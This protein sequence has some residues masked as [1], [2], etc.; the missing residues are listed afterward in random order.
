MGSNLRVLNASA[1]SGKTTRLVNEYLYLILQNS[2]PFAFKEILAITF[3]NKAAL[4]MKQRIVEELQTIAFK[5]F[6]S[7]DYLTELQQKTDLTNQEFKERASNSLF[8]ILH[9]YSDFAISTIDAFVLKILKTFSKDLGLPSGFEVNLDE[10]KALEQAILNLIENARDEKELLKFITE[11][12]LQRLSEEKSWNVEYTL[13]DFCKIL[14]TAENNNSIKQLAK[15]PLKDFVAIREYIQPKIEEFEKVLKSYGDK[16]YQLIEE[17][18]VDLDAFPQGARSG[19]GTYFKKLADGE[20]KEL[21]KSVLSFLNKDYK[22]KVT[23]EQKDGIDKVKEELRV[24]LKELEEFEKEYRTAYELHKLIL[25]SLY[26]MG[27]LKEVASLLEKSKNEENYILISDFNKI[28]TDAIKEEPAPFIY[29]RTG[30]R[31]K[32]IFIDEFQDTSVIQWQNLFPLVENSLGG[33]NQVLI[34]GDVKQSIY[35]WRGGEAEQLAKFPEPVKVSASEK[36]RFNVLQNFMAKTEPLV[37][38]YRSEKKIIEFNNFLFSIMQENV[39][40]NQKSFFSDFKQDTPKKEDQGYVEIIFFEDNDLLKETQLNAVLSIVSKLKSQNL[41]LNNIA[42][43]CRK[44]DDVAEMVSYLTQKS[45]PVISAEGLLVKNSKRVCLIASCIIYLQ[46]FGKSKELN[47]KLSYWLIKNGFAELSDLNNLSDNLLSEVFP[48]KDLKELNDAST[49]TVA[50][51]LAN[52]FGFLTE[53]DAFVVTFLNALYD[54]ELEIHTKYATFQDWWSIEKDNIAIESPENVNAVQVMSIHK[55]K[56]LQFET[57]ILPYTWYDTTLRNYAEWVKLAPFKSNLEEFYLP[58]SK[59]GASIV[60]FSENHETEKNKT[61]LDSFNMLYVACTRPKKNLYIF[62]KLK[63]KSNGKIESLLLEAASNFNNLVEV[64]TNHWQ[65]GQPEHSSAK[66][67]TKQNS[68]EVFRHFNNWKKKI[69]VVSKLLPYSNSAMEKGIAIHE[70][71]EQVTSTESLNSTWFKQLEGGLQEK[72][73]Q[74]VFHPELTEAYSEKNQLNER[75]ILLKDGTKYRPDKVTITNSTTFLIDYKTG[76]K[77]ETHKKQLLEYTDA[78]KAMGYN[79][80]K[81]FLAYVD[82]NEVEPIN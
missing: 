37:T 72:I 16:G 6:S 21:N 3:T 73:K 22:S 20:P 39:A 9:N 77:K 81:P 80:I 49:A 59:D 64:E 68:F 32:H 52:W 25:K 27:M 18:Q 79:N 71:F 69:K 2:N 15:H 23:Q 60:G 75:E 35:R 41:P 51:T 70:L 14:L 74:I 26:P 12:T 56:G 34:V 82:L 28:V 4:E 67:Q 66:N 30:E 10:E 19:A 29:H 50:E 78:L 40:D 1:G 36:A 54:S 33:G 55:S 45:I 65:Y 57:V 47:A 58:L 7:I 48:K 8:S 5:D 24:Y 43:L 42:I 44:N 63:E 38:N 61:I 31:F 46:N 13:L 76:E 62:S 17:N 11:F 53:D